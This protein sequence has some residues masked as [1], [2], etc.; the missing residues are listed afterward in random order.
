M[1]LSTWLKTVEKIV[2]TLLKL[3]PLAP[4]SQ[5]VALG[6]QTAQ[7]IKGATGAQKL[8]LAKQIVSVGVAAT[9]AQAGHQVVDPAEVDALV[10]SSI[11]TVVAAANLAHKDQK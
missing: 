7:Q 1:N 9:N 10:T 3:T 2:P 6:I 5:Y 4:I 11:N 8:E